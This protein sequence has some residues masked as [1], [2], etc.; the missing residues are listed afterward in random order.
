LVEENV[1]LRTQ[2]FIEDKWQAVFHGKAVDMVRELFSS[3]PSPPHYLNLSDD[4]RGTVTLA[5][6]HS[7]STRPAMSEELSEEKR[8]DLEYYRH[9]RGSLS[10]INFMALDL[11][12]PPTILSSVALKTKDLEEYS[13]QPL[14]RNRLIY[15]HQRRGLYR[16]SVPI[17][18]ESPPMSHGNLFNS[19]RNYFGKEGLITD[20]NPF[21][22]KPGTRHWGGNHYVTVSLYPDDIAWVEISVDM[23]IVYA[24]E[25]EK[26][27]QPGSLLQYLGSFPYL[28]TCWVRGWRGRTEG[29][30]VVRVRPA[31]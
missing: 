14:P 21:M 23:E 12:S 28:L 27:T 8:Y 30:S 6:L 13:Y 24:R 15:K 26:V 16:F 5:L 9:R 25:Q 18:A 1:F 17:S 2:Y 3:N 11:D 31:A 19:L 22:R 7:N 4:L 10:L 29:L 20:K